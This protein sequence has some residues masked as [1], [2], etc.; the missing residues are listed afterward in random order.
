MG[1]HFPPGLIPP[2]QK[3][4]TNNFGTRDFMQPMGR[5]NMHSW[6]G[7]EWGEGGYFLFFFLVQSLPLPLAQ[8]KK[9]DQQFW[10]PK[11]H[12]GNG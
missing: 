7:W 9:G 10:K 1:H 11:I 3:M 6:G 8:A 5:L 4:V 12:A 2:R